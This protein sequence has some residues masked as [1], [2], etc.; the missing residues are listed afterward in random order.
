MS[1]TAASLGVFLV[2]K[3]HNADARAMR[4]S[5][6]SRARG[7]IPEPSVLA[8]APPDLLDAVEPTENATS[9]TAQHS[10]DE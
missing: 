2:A 9:E 7:A 5:L 10:A 6:A 8:A 3:N 4:R 1:L